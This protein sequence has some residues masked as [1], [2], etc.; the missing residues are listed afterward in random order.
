MR[1]FAPVLHMAHENELFGEKHMFDTTFYPQALT[2]PE[3]IAVE[4]AQELVHFNY[5]I[6]NYRHFVRD[7][8][9]GW[10]DTHFRL[11]LIRVLVD[12]FD[13]E[14]SGRYLL[15]SLARLAGYLGEASAPV[16][17]P[18][19]AAG[20]KSYSGLRDLL[21]RALTGPWMTG[22]GRELAARALKPFDDFYGVS[23][24]E[25]GDLG[26]PATTPGA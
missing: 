10:R 17:Y 6:S 3:L 11:L 21:S 26:A 14:G 8:E 2:A 7:R 15:P 20:Q 23:S 4:P 18:D 9:K 25:V 13:E 22:P 24:T 1:S 5:V 12:L 19:P 16:Q